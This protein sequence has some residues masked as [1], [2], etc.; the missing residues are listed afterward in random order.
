MPIHDRGPTEKKAWVREPLLRRLLRVGALV[1]FCLGFAHTA[2]AQSGLS[3]ETVPQGRW[4]VGFKLGWD[5][6]ETPV[7]N[8]GAYYGATDRV[9]IGVAASPISAGL[10]VKTHVLGSSDGTFRISALA[11]IRAFFL[12]DDS[13]NDD[14]WIDVGFDG[15]MNLEP[16][17]IAEWNIGEERRW[18]VAAEIGSTHFYGH[19]DRKVLA[20][21]GDDDPDDWSHGL[22][23]TLGINYRFN[24]GWALGATGG[25]FGGSSSVAPVFTVGFTKSF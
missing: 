17:L 3:A 25:V 12:P 11:A 5:I 16:R 22:R 19:Y 7:F 23:A 2:N 1:C 13:N 21:G 10:S 20:N 18:G 6:P 4:A 9:Q 15:G 8:L 24:E 14:D